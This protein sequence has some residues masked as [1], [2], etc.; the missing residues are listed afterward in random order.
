[1]YIA[2]K[3]VKSIEWPNEADIYS[4]TLYE[5]SISESS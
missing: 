2:V 1:M 4:E 3:E 5:D